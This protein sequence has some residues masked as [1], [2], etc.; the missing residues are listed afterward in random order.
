[1]IA[2]H[3]LVVLAKYLHLMQKVDS[4]LKIHVSSD[5]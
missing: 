2:Q 4:V 5:T 3:Q 1:M